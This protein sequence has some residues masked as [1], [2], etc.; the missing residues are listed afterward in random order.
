MNDCS[1]GNKSDCLTSCFK[2]RK[3][4]IEREREKK[5]KIKNHINI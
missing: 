1:K 4:I 2:E 3:H 5:N